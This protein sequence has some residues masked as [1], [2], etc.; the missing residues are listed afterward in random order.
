MTGLS[1]RPIFY[2]PTLPQH[3]E[4]S[5]LESGIEGSVV[6]PRHN[7]TRQL[8]ALNQENRQ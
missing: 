5:W 7:K 3:N 1:H 2:Q 4:S 6:R 8:F